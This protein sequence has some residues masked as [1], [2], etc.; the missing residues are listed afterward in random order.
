MLREL[1]LSRA[2]QR[3]SV[4]PN[5]SE[6]KLDPG[7][8]SPQLAVWRA[9]I[10]RLA[11]EL[12]KL[13]EA[14]GAAAAGE[15]YAKFSAAATAREAAEKA[16]GEAKKASDEVSAALAAAIHEVETKDDALKALLAA[17]TAAEAAAAKLPDD[18]QLA[19]AA[20]T[21]KTRAGEFDAQLAAARKSVSEKQPQVQAASVKLAEADKALQTALAARTQA[22]ATVETADAAAQDAAQKFR[23]AK[24]QHAELAARAADAERALAYQQLRGAAE[25]SQAA[26]AA[27]KLAALAAQQQSAA[28]QTVQT[29]V[30]TAQ[31]KAASDRAAADTAWNAL[32]DRGAVRF[33]VAPLKPLSPEQLAW[34]TMQAAGV[35]DTQRAALE[36]EARKEAEAGKGPLERLLEVRVDEKLRGNIAQFVSLFGQQPGQAPTFQATVHQALF[37]SNGGLLAGWLNPGGGNLTER[38]ARIED[39][40]ALADELYLTVLTRRPAP[41]E[42]AAVADFWKAGPDERPARARE[43]VWS[44]VTSAEFRFNR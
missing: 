40:Q 6:W 44:L 26:A 21:I 29:E 38:L 10:E 39:P 5:P 30:K 19:E 9:E 33:T 43:M 2:Y 32:L 13:K 42:T 35:V 11:A 22:A 24:A 37:L 14:A 34:S 25:V 36:G 27:E 18:K 8:V 23:T 12:P 28:D 41:E 16:R 7:V 4:P 31:D 3:S 17:R 1:A 20:A 15:A